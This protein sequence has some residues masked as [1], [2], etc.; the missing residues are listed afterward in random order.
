M[1]PGRLLTLWT[2][3]HWED[4]PLA[5]SSN[6]AASLLACWTSLWHPELLLHTRAVPAFWRVDRAA[7]LDASDVVAVPDDAARK[8]TPELRRGVESSAVVLSGTSRTEILRQLDGWGLFGRPLSP[9]P[10]FHALGY[11]WLQLHLMTRSIRFGDGIDESQ[12]RNRLWEAAEA[13]RAEAP[14]AGATEDAEHSHGGHFRAAV[15]ACFDQL[16]AERNRYYPADASLCR[17]VL[18]RPVTDLA[19]LVESTGQG[20]CSVL[21]APAD[22]ATCAHAGG[23]AWSRLRERLADGTTTWLSAGW[24][25]APEP[26]ICCGTAVRQLF[27]GRDDHLRIAGREAKVLARR[28]GGFS[29]QTPA[30][31]SIAG[32]TLGLPATFDSRRKPPLSAPAAQ[33]KSPCGTAIQALSVAPLDYSDPATLLRLGAVVGE[34]ADSWHASHVLLAHWPGGRC[35]FTRDLEITLEFGRLLGRFRTLEQVAATLQPQTWGESP[36]ADSLDEAVLQSGWLDVPGNA[37]RLRLYHALLAECQTLRRACLLWSLA[38]QPAAGCLDQLTEL[39]DEVDDLLA[40]ENSSEKAAAIHSALAGVR[41][42]LL[43]TE[44]REERTGPPGSSLTRV[45]MN[46]STSRLASVVTVTGSDSGGNAAPSTSV[47]LSEPVPGGTR[48]L[49]HPPGSSLTRLE[50]G[51]VEKNHRKL[52]GPAILDGN[53]LRNDFLT[54]E[55]DPHNGAIRSIRKTG[56][57]VTLASQRLSYR[58]PAGPDGSVSWDRQVADSVECRESGKIAAAL[59]IRGR[60]GARY[61][62]EQTIRLARLQPWVTLELHIEPLDGQEVASPEAYLCSRLA[63]QNGDAHRYRYQLG[64][65]ERCCLQRFTSPVATEIELE[66][67]LL[68]LL[69]FGNAWHQQSAL[70]ILDTALT[71]ERGAGTDGR[72]RLAIGINIADPLAVSESIAVAP[73]VFLARGPAAQS[74]GRII[75]WKAGGLHW[76]DGELLKSGPDPVI[77]FD[78]REMFGRGGQATLE[79]ARPPTSAGLFDLAGNPLTGAKVE[80]RRVHVQYGAWQL[81]SVQVA[82]ESSSSIHS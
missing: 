22:L 31:A 45:F 46:A 4:F 33:W 34:Q 29:Q 44:P 77:R 11:A 69:T 30:V 59:L 9:V 75:E 38:G 19:R 60:I 5:L 21:A 32:W 47:P 10:E 67:D 17:I 18:A 51:T 14:A 48:W 73:L 56:A 15:Q 78:L 53:L 20:P 35:E 64:A 40:A 81:F 63:W 41:S 1:S 71:G 82:W 27:R 3:H 76:Y 36:E 62:F 8:L 68:T 58:N 13:W 12:F 42:Q 43:E 37:Q 16:L 79:F 70:N 52:S 65:R 55:V 28:S 7:D 66:E 72:F 39:R 26:L 25:E 2:C 24:C 50:S 49:A 6:D 74:A 23:E 61:R 57:A 80:G 54:V